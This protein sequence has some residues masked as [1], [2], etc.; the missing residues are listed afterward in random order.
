M[1]FLNVVM[2]FIFRTVV[3]KY[4]GIQVQG[5]NGLFTEVLAALSLVELGVGTA[6]VYNLYKPLAEGNHEKIKQLMLLFKRAYRI[7]AVATMIIG[8]ILC[9][10]IHL[11]VKAVNYPLWYIRVV[12]LL[13]VLDISVSYLYSY[14]ISL[15][16]AD[17]KNYIFAK[18]DTVVKILSVVVRIGIIILF[19]EFI[20]Y[21]AAGIAITIT[22]N[23]IKSHIVDKQYSWLN[24]DCE[25]LSKEERDSVFANIKNLFIKSL[26][27]KITNSTD[28]ILISTLVNTI[29]VGYYSNYSLVIG[30]FRQVSNQVAYSGIGASLGDM[31]ATESAERCKQVF[32]RLYYIFF[33]LATVSAV[34]IHVCMEPFILI[35][36]KS[37]EFVMAESV[38]VICCLNMFIEILNRPLWSVME[39]SGLFQY[40]K[41]AS[42][43]GSVINL[44]VSIWLGR[45]IG[46]VGIFIGTFLTYAIQVVIKAYLLFRMKFDVSP[47]KYYL[48]TLV[49][50]AGYGVLLCLVKF[51][52]CFVHL[53]NNFLQFV[54]CGMISTSVSLVAIL[55]VTFRTEQFAY[56]KSLGIKA[57]QKVLKKN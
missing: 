48:V 36:W 53:N 31:M 24:E 12:Y 10:F 55:L 47:L 39:V 43:A 2:N 35:W 37:S 26:S 13:F 52:C 8:L 45:K 18:I 1:Q 54:V 42:I 33:V 40:D 56:V 15:I 51:L 29:Q 11:I 19:R 4:M 38:L 57:I 49:A 22:T 44:F 23:V 5:L 7:I 50:F 3:I 34:S 30:L 6:I 21:L 20:A 27:G 9:P 25:P 32:Y 14:K 16:I 46:I 28:N 17:Q 41:W